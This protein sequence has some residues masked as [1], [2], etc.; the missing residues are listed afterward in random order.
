MI[1][2]DWS[3]SVIWTWQNPYTQGPPAAMVA[4]QELSQNKQ[5]NYLVCN[6]SFHFYQELLA[7]GCQEGKKLFFLWM[8]SLLVDYIPLD[9]PISVYAYMDNQI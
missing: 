6:K 7:N 5:L 3:N 1:V 2:E 9:E 4:G 8:W